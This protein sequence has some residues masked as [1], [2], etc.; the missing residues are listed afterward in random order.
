MIKF[1]EVAF[2]PQPK[3]V[4]LSGG[5]RLVTPFIPIPMCAQNIRTIIGVSFLFQTPYFPQ[6]KRCYLR[7]WLDCLELFE[8]FG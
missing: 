2:R 5:S 4:N 7:D 8:K 6:C 1:R 3:S